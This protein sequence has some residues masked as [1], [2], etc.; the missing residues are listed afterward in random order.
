[1]IKVS[2]YACFCEQGIRGNNEDFVYPTTAESGNRIFVLCDGMGGYENG[3]VASEMVAMA[4]CRFLEAQCADVYTKEMLDEALEFACEE[5]DKAVVSTDK[6]RMG[7]TLVVVVLNEWEILIGHIGDSRCYHWGRDGEKRFRTMDHSQ[8]EEAVRLGLIT[9]DEAFRHPKKNILTRCIQAGSGKKIEMTIDRLT[10]VKEGDRILLCTDGVNDALSDEGLE[11]LYR[12]HAESLTGWAE[13]VKESCEKTSRDN[14][15][16]LFVELH[17]EGSLPRPE[18]TVRSQPVLQ[19]ETREGKLCMQCQKPNAVYARFCVYCGY[20]LDEQDDIFTSSQSPILKQVDGPSR[21]N[22][23]FMH[24]PSSGKNVEISTFFMM[25]GSVI[26][27]LVIIVIILGFLL[28]KRDKQPDWKNPAFRENL[29]KMNGEKILKI[30][31]TKI[32]NVYNYSTFKP[33]TNEQF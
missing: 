9:E 28:V 20:N 1:M 26:V 4:V 33:F 14:Y 27:G 13:A 22:E 24:L 18:E 32:E 5:L 6:S 17:V 15:S 19:P 7:T 2:N 16:A 21:Q 3:E 25:L 8:V 23:K 29:E 10:D 30:T 12:E 31:E 11:R